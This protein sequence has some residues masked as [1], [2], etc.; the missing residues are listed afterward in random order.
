MPTAMTLSSK[1]QFTFNKQLMEH[2]NVKAGEKILIKKMPD[3]SLRIEAEKSQIDIM[4]LAGSLKTTV[5][6]TD[7][8]LQTAIANSYVQAGLKGLK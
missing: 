7:E 8:E 3:G 4:S 1:G 6:L 2:L 5:R